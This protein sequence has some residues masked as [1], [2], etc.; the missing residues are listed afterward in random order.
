MCDCHCSLPTYVPTS[1]PTY[2][3]T[4]VQVSVFCFICS[5]VWRECEEAECEWL[6]AFGCV[7][8]P[9]TMR[10]CVCVRERERE[11]EGENKNNP[12]TDFGG[13]FLRLRQSHHFQL[14]HSTLM[15]LFSFDIV[16]VALMLLFLP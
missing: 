9:L 11:R 7:G 8:V 4:W 3:P 1:L 2:L 16:V 5:F 12:E 10:V 6:S 14:R 13:F 15:L